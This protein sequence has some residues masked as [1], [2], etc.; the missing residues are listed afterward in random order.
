MLFPTPTGDTQDNTRPTK[1]SGS[2]DE[3]GNV[4][5]LL[6][7]TSTVERT[8]LSVLGLLFVKVSVQNGQDAADS[9]NESDDES[10]NISSLLSVTETVETHFF[11]S[12]L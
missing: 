7:V 11:V 8:P 2:D 3:S 5:S 12:C 10:G 9:S 1:R 4:N 6:L